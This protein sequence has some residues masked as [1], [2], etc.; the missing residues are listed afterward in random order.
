[1]SVMM[2]L[3]GFVFWGCRL[4]ICG[5]VRFNA[6]LRRRCNRAYAGSSGAHTFFA[7]GYPVLVC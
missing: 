4:D 5:L 6:D 1:M 3:T 2:L 7:D